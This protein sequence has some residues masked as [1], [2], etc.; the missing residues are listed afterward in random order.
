MQRASP[1]QRK[2]K[3]ILDITVAGTALIVLAP[4]FVII[5][6]AIRLTSPGP[7]FYR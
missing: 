7:V 3:R 1:W 5:A 2:V 6:T 4:V